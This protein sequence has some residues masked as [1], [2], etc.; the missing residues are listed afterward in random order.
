MARSYRISGQGVR[1]SRLVEQ[2]NLPRS[3]GHTGA[4]EGARSDPL[5]DGSDGGSRRNSRR[6]RCA[7]APRAGARSGSG[8]GSRPH[9][10][11]AAWVGEAGGGGRGRRSSGRVDD[12]RARRTRRTSQ[13]TDTGATDDD[14]TGLGRATRAAS[15]ADG[16]EHAGLRGVWRCGHRARR[17]PPS[18]PPLTCAANATGSSTRTRARPADRGLVGAAC[19]EEAL[20]G[21]NALALSEREPQALGV[22]LL[23]YAA[24][25]EGVTPERRQALPDGRRRVGEAPAAFSEVGAAPPKLEGKRAQRPPDPREE[26]S[27]TGV[28]SQPFRLPSASSCLP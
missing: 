2:M 22:P 23:R 21:R 16:A 15:A 1:V 5:Q 19:E 24:P 3:C 11:G 6:M 10:N 8:D 27:A 25:E 12:S 7:S 4:R 26:R 17:G 18:P 9:R 20:E 14:G 28:A 13:P